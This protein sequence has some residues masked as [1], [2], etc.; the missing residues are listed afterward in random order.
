MAI[1]L[2]GNQITSIKLGDADVLSVAL[3]DNLV[4]Q[5]GVTPTGV[6]ALKFTNPGSSSVDLFILKQGSP[7]VNLT[8]DDF[9]MSTDGGDTWTT[10]SGDSS[11]P[12]RQEIQ[13]GQEILLRRKGSGYLSDSSGYYQL[14]AN[15]LLL[16]SGPIRAMLGDSD[17]TAPHEVSSNCFRDFFAGSYLSAEL[18]FGGITS[19]QSGAFYNFN[20]YNVST[21][22]VKNLENDLSAEPNS[23]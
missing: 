22:T 23:F 17:A 8:N 1:F 6:F 15:G 5:G 2:G 20:S 3:G 13:A 14:A 4:W 11:Q 7:T 10:P 18:D 16:V 21:L 12:V 9:E 19:A